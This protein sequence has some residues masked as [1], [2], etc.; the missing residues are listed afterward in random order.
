[1]IRIPGLPDL[2]SC[3][4]SF[5]LYK[6]FVIINDNYSGLTEYSKVVQCIA[7]Y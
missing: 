7:Y 2:V 4:T 3:L 6:L 1:M 5:V